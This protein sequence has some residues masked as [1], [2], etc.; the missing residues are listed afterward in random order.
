MP[1]H[2]HKLVIVHVGQPGVH[3]QLDALAWQC[4]SGPHLVC[5]VEN[6][7]LCMNMMLQEGTRGWTAVPRS[8]HQ[9]R[10]WNESRTDL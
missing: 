10:I 3:K 7:G 1:A 8:W 9:R 4:C 5:Q 6:D 2:A